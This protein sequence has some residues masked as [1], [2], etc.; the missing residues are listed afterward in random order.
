MLKKYVFRSNRAGY[1]ILFLGAIHGNEPAGTQAIS[2]AVQKFASGALIPLKGT[3]SFIPVCNPLAFERNVR[4]IDENLNRVIRRWNNPTTYEQNLANE[5]SAEIEV[6]D[7]ILDL[8]SSHCPDDKPFIFN[9]YP[10]DHMACRLS[11]VQ[12]IEYVVEGWPQIYNAA[13]IKDYSTG[14]WAKICGKTCLTVECGYHLSDTAVKTAYHVIMNTLL[15]LDVLEGFSSA[16]PKQKY[17]AMD[18]FFIKT[19]SGR[20]ARPFK[21][22]DPI[23]AGELLA[24]YDNGTSVV[25]PQDGFI[26]L[27]NPN[28]AV[29]TEWF[30]LGHQK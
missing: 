6:A 20:L 1:N 4:Q 30:Y 23:S 13:P 19:G 21:H 7:I 15:S 18:G 5:L 3:V 29:G 17:I 8:H 12:N 9:D 16:L 28:A 24:F 26:M 25:C 11:S 22:L 14:S 10:D 27:P 2:T